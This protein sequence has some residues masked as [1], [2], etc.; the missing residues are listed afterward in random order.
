MKK[1]H[2]LKLLFVSI[3]ALLLVLLI[4]GCSPQ[5]RLNRL[6]A[7]NPE[8]IKEN[9]SVPGSTI[10]PAVHMDS[11]FFALPGDTIII[12]QEKIRTEFIRLPNDSFHINTD[13]AADTIRCWVKV[14]KVMV[15]AK[16]GFINMP[17]LWSDKAYKIAFF[18]LLGSVFI[19][20]VK[21]IFWSRR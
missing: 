6:L 3:L 12:E 18:M 10:Q 16:T 11:T 7:L 4:A 1:D 21:K 13:K 15:T 17:W 19:Y 8:L 14:P 2:Q 9:D 5:K 20:G